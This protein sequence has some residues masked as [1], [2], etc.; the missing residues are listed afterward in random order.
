MSIVR[1]IS[2]KTIG[3]RVHPADLPKSGVQWLYRAFGTARGTQSGESSYGPWACLVGQ[4]RA[5]TEDGEQFDAGKLFLPGSGHDLIVG[6][7]EGN[8]AVEFG[9]RVGAKI[10]RES[11]VGYVYVVEPL[12]KAQE[13]DPLERMTRMLLKGPAAD[14]KA[15]TGDQAET[16]DKAE[17]GNQQKPATRR[18]SK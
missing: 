16:G 3:V 4:F 17:T 11:S 18:G 7:M 2:T 8:D 5:I 10:D 12:F 13:G 9:V 6:A 1:K 14:D 15:E